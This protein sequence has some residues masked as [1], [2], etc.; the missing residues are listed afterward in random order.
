VNVRVI[1]RTA[2]DGY[3]KLVRLPFDAAVGLLPEN[4]TGRGTAATLVFDRVDAAARTLA[5]A[6]LGDPVLREDAARRHRAAD[7]RGRA[8]RLRAQAE[9]RS[10]GAESRLGERQD[11]AA[12]QRQRAKQ[13]AEATR[14]QAERRREQKTRQAAKT[15]SKRR[16]TSRKAAARVDG[17][18][19]ARARKA[20]LKTLDS[21]ADALRERE[22]ALTASDE[23][24]RLSGAASKAKA[25]R[26][27][28]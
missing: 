14:R 5:G 21:K 12:R 26:K 20:R 16:G 15:E 7:E 23:A 27:K 6:V 1:P 22:E 3:L 19:D 18:V 2:V 24:R 28:G 25:A 8:F 9:R 13:R 4:G 11:Q 10:E 17:A